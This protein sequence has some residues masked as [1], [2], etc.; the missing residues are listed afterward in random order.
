MNALKCQIPDLFWQ[1]ECTLREGY[2]VIMNEAKAQLCKYK[3]K[4]NLSWSEYIIIIYYKYLPYIL[5]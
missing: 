5:R 3:F 1:S 2:P 4:Y